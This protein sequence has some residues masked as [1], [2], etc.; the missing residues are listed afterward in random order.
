[1]MDLLFLLRMGICL[2]LSEREVMSPESGKWHLG[3]SKE[4]NETNL[5][6]DESLWI[7]CAS[8]FLPE[9][10]PNVVNA[11]LLFNIIDKLV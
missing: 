5:G 4:Y 7:E 2:W 1:M 11:K 6:F 3:G 8:L 9:N 10:R